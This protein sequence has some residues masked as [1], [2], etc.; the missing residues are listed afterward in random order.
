MTH[1]PAVF[2][3]MVDADYPSVANIFQLGIDGGNATYE[4]APA[5]WEQWNSDHCFSGRWVAQHVESAEIIGWV[6][7]SWVS[8]RAVFRGVA[9]LSVYVHP[10]FQGL[11]IGEKLMRLAIEE[12]EEDGFWMLQSGIFPENKASIALHKKMG[13]RE[14]GYREKIGKMP[15]TGV[16]RDIV[17]MERR[18]TPINE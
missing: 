11:G 13:F 5:S 1:L 17:L 14:V 9:E 7:L 18:V 12:S 4:V 6:A 8:N 15:L 16:W 2:R 10:E 3:K